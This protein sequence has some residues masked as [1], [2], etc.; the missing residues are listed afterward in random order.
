MY[1]IM[2]M[3]ITFVIVI[4]ACHYHVTRTQ[5]AGAQ[6]QTVP[7]WD[8]NSTMQTC[9]VEHLQDG[10]VNFQGNS[11]EGCN[12]QVLA[13]SN[14]FFVIRMPA[15]RVDSGVF[16]YVERMDDFTDCPKQYVLIEEERESCG[17][18]F[19][20]N[21]LIVLHLYGNVIVSIRGITP[22]EELQLECPELAV[23]VNGGGQLN[24]SCQSVHGYDQLITCY[25]QDEYHTGVC[26]ISFPSSC[27]AF[28]GKKEVRFE[29]SGRE[30]FSSQTLLVLIPPSTSVLHLDKNEIIEIDANAFQHLPN[31]RQLH[32]YYTPLVE[33]P[34]Y[35][36]EG[37][38]LLTRL[39]LSD[40]KLYTLHPR[41]FK[42]LENLEWL[43]L[44]KNKLAILNEELFRG[45]SNLVTLSLNGNE[46]LTL[47]VR[48]FEGLDNLGWLYLSN[49]MLR[50][51]PLGIF[52]GL[53]ALTELDLNGNE[54]RDLPAKLFH[55]LSYLST[56]KISQNKLASLNE[57][58]FDGLTSLVTLFLNDNGLLILP[59]KI[60]EGLDNLK[61]LRIYN[62][63]LHTLP[64]EVLKKL[65]VLTGLDLNDNEF[66]DL[67]AELFHGLSYLNILYISRNKLASLNESLLMV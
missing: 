7:L 36:F 16:F 41:V 2:G 17:T 61:W 26:R 28:L 57:E 67:P 12:L 4:I 29:C 27:S 51:L 3:L 64:A 48:I 50:T 14:T 56:L 20:D 63:M 66:T 19:V 25:N 58:L 49:N 46:L 11:F 59:L 13:P 60:F 39:F 1:S 54:L 23:N 45:L 33:L 9:Q 8:T 52:Q 55:G 34:N 43:D 10:L 40:N 44:F 18:S 37:S 30:P 35:L 53:T 32:L 21:D 42:G 15:E 31:L 5:F 24:N 47:P 38:P 22:S 62:N 6:I 65:T